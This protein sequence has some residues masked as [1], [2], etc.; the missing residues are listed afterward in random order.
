MSVL[1]YFQH[2]PMRSAMALWGVMIWAISFS[3]AEAA[4][5]RLY[6]EKGSV[7]LPSVKIS[8]TE[9]L[10]LV[11][12]ADAVGKP[13]ERLQARGSY[14]IPLGRSP[15]TL[16]IGS[17]K[18]RV[19]QA[20]VMLSVPPRRFDGKAVI[21][22]ELL[23][24]ALSARYGED[25]VH[26][27][28]EARV[29][30]IAQQAYSL[31]LLRFRTY[32]DH[33]RVVLEGS[34]PHDFILREDGASGRVVLDVKQGIVS[35]S[36]RSSQVSDGLVA[37]FEAR[38]VGHDTR[39]TIH[40]AGGRGLW[41]KI[42]AI[43]GPNRIVIDLFP[44]GEQARQLRQAESVTKTTPGR[45]EQPKSLVRGVE[46]TD[47]SGGSF[48]EQI[49]KTVVID[50][51]HGGRDPGAIGQSGVKEKDIVLK[52][53]LTLQQLIEENLGMKV[54]MTRTED[55]FVPLE[56]RTMIANQHRADFFISLHVNAAPESRAVGVETYF[57]SREPSDRGA[58]ASAVRENTVLNLEGVGQN[59]QRGLK[60]VLWDL[61]QTFYVRESS[62]LAELLLNE[63]GKSLKMD[64][65]GVKS[66]PFFVLIG[67][68]MPSVLVE[69]AFITN[70]QEEQKLEQ[71]TYRQQVA[72]ALLAGIARF[73]TRYEKRVGLMPMSSSENSRR[74]SAF[75]SQKR[76]ERESLVLT[77]DR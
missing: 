35:P 34:R 3:C 9:Y 42:F 48:P 1:R 6:L 65:R 30:R 19:G 56:S 11:S 59:A 51:G 40:S 26:W 7:T 39:I 73:K 4:Q 68:A 31:R 47:P 66:A 64:N 27:D 36:I 2:P 24:I 46:P 60:T 58:R 72:E 20:V 25:R 62:E 44:R 52:I 70:A 71:E 67:A 49:V 69:V 77:S 54:I 37:S 22:L 53:G 32:T 55:V 15:L 12:L 38:Q 41:S 16:V 63:L 33:T 29:A 10:S 8:G 23:P 50:P 13:L 14:R 5:V 75:S 45:A 43:G 18:I 74:Q 57:L 61:T 28:A 17:P 21:P 76:R